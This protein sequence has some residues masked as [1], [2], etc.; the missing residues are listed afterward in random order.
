MSGRRYRPLKLAFL[1]SILAA[2]SFGAARIEYVGT[3]VWSLP[4]ADFGGFSGI[5]VSKD[6]NSFHILSDRA[7]IRWGS[8]DRDSNG[9]I[10]NMLMAGRAQLQDSKG[11][12]LQ[13][14]RLGDSEGLAID[15]EGRVWISFE[16]LDRIARYDD[17]DGP[18]QRVD[19]PDE[20]DDIRTNEGFEALAVTPEGTLLTLPEY[21]VEDMQTFPVWRYRA[22]RWDQPF[23]ISGSA[24]WQAT[25]AD[26]GP[27]GR[28]YL[29]ERSFRG[30]LGFL[31][32]VRRFSLDENG[33]GN[34]EILLETTTLQYDNLEG[35]SVWD[36]GLGIRLTMVS[37]D[38]FLPVQRTELVEYRVLE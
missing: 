31:S 18:A 26:I 32:R 17:I 23:S 1:L 15:G 28:L 35:I 38:N 3:Y 22:G 11:T 16:G 21:A 2:P 36:D 33:A 34:E 12:P 19:I 13:P 6:G 8:F 20:W 25:G 24:K 4:E 5:E 14:G 27:D 29:L 9:R 37:D 7:W 10:R 30:V